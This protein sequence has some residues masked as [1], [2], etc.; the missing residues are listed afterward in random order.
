M[1]TMEG[2]VNEMALKSNLKGLREALSEY[3]GLILSMTKEFKA[4]QEKKGQGMFKF[5]QRPKSPWDGLE[6]GRGNKV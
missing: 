4:L 5:V 2:E 1:L 6:V 3:Q